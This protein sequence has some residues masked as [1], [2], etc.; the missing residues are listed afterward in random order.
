[1]NLLTPLRS[2]LFILGV[3][4]SNLALA[5]VVIALWPFP[6]AA[7]FAVSQVWARFTLW[8][9]KVV[10]GLRFE[11]EGLENIPREPGIVLSKHQ[12]AF[13]TIALQVIFMPA[14]FILKR[15]LL[16]I[17]FWGWAT[18]CMEPIA[19]DR[20]SKTS[21]LKQ[22]LKYGAER[23]KAGRW[24]I[25]FPEG[26]RVPPGQK[27]TYLP[28]GAMLAKKLGCPVVPVAH[29][30]GEFWPRNAFNKRPGLIH[31]RIGAPLDIQ[32]CSADEINRKSEAWIE[33]NTREISGIAV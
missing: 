21:A 2:A 27:G 30:A 28:G 25:V 32:G 8:L 1:M 10:C 15:E 3:W 24:V 18:A 31:I 14:S 6:F 12:S 17:P 22:I 20:S 7:R 33:Q 19:I 5:P 9:L 13:E 29:N 16:Y 23:V 26:T 4:A 11:I